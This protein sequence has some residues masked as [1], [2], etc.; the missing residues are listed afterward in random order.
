MARIQIR[1]LTDESVSAE[2]MKKVYGGLSA[3][4]V[5]TL[6]TNQP[7]PPGSLVMDLCGGTRSGCQGV[8]GS[9][10]NPGDLVSLPGMNTKL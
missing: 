8:M 3:I 1:D 4:Q 10:L 2:E 6:G 7:L 5:P 9:F